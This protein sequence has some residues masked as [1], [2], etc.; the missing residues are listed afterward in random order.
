[1]RNPRW[2]PNRPKEIRKNR[3]VRRASARRTPIVRKSEAHSA[4]KLNDARQIVLAVTWPNWEP[5]PSG[6]LNCVRLNKL[7]NSPR[8]SNAN[9]LIRAKLRVLEGGKV[10]VLL[11][12]GTYV[13][14]G[15][16]IGAIPIVVRIAGCEYRSVV[17]LSDFWVFEP[18]SR[19]DGAVLVGRAQPV[20]GMPELL[21]AP[22]Q[23][24]TIIG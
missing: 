2:Q 7:K 1:M 12:V 24:P 20:S 11:S 21:S 6:G 18:P 13:R 8:N 23:P 5:Q 9:R 19:C 14:L 16:R 15:T 4:R 17:P 3:C 10:E 22:G